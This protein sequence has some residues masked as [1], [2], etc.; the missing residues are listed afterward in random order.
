MK[1]DDPGS[2]GAPVTMDV[3]PHF[4]S[5]GDKKKLTATTRDVCLGIT[6]FDC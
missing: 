6:D 2:L 5:V 3:A 1:A 4:S